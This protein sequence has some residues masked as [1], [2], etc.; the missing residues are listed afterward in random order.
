MS[1]VPIGILLFILLVVVPPIAILR[2]KYASPKK[3]RMWFLASLLGIPIGLLWTYIDI[4]RVVAASV[5]GE[6]GKDLVSMPA[7]GNLLLV[8]WPVG[9]FLLFRILNTQRKE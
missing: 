7:F 9:V 8:F 2:S 6:R 5:D 4:Q 3:R 1:G